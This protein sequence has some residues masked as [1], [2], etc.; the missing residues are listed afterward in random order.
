MD[1]HDL[2]HAL[3]D[4]NREILRVREICTQSGVVQGLDQLIVRVCSIGDAV[5]GS[6]DI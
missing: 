1:K 6:N 4:L 5:N 3:T 2:L